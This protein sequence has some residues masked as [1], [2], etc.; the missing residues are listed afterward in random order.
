MRKL[1]K[2]LKSN[3]GFLEYFEGEIRFHK[4]VEGGHSRKRKN[5]YSSN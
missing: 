5:L 2:A 1:E 3:I 4:N